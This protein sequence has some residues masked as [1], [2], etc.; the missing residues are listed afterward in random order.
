MARSSSELVGLADRVCLG[1]MGLG[2]LLMLQPYWLPGLE[3]GFFLTLCSTV[4]EIVTAHL[5]PKVGRS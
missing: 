1:F 5:L 2:T 3:V 4:L